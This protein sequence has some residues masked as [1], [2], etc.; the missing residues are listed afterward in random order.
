VQ[1]ASAGLFQADAVALV[2]ELGGRVAFIHRDADP[3]LP[4]A[5]CQAQ[6][7]DAA[8]DDEDVD[9]QAGTTAV[10]AS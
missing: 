7:T 9:W 10:R 6:T 3:G 5:L 1:G 8:A 4:Q 2:P